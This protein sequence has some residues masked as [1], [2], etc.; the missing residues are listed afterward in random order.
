MYGSSALPNHFLMFKSVKS[1]L[2]TALFSQTAAETL[3]IL[4]EMHRP[5]PHPYGH[6]GVC[7]TGCST[8]W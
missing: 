3:A 1:H 4:V 6:R 2:V 7:S 8:R 5:H